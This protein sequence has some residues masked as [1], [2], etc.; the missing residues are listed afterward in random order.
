MNEYIQERHSRRTSMI[1][2]CC[3]DCQ[4][5]VS[6]LPRR[7]VDL[8]ALCL[9]FSP[10]V[11]FSGARFHGG[12]RYYPLNLQLSPPGLRCLA[13]RRAAVGAARAGGGV[14]RSPFIPRQTLVTL[15]TAGGESITVSCS[16]PAS[17]PLINE[18]EMRLLAP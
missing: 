17:A 13:Q 9:I 3:L 15:S 18:R 6:I 16:H 8:A 1:T 11:R 5:T 4:V 10:R 2:M 14:I 7:H 12:V